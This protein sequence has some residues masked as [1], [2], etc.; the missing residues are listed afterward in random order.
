M[1]CMDEAFVPAVTQ[2]DGSLVCWS[3]REWLC[4]WEAWKSLGVSVR[5]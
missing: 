5:L 2:L 1:W 3:M 4:N